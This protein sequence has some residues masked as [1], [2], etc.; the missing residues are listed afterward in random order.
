[1]C[2]E[3]SAPEAPS[4]PGEITIR[5]CR[6]FLF[7]FALSVLVPQQSFA[8]SPQNGTKEQKVLV[9]QDVLDMLKTGLPADIVAAKIKASNCNFNTDLDAL[10]ELKEKGIADNVVLAMVQ[11]PRS[12]IVPSDGKIRAFITDSQSWEV[13]GSWG[14]ANG[15]GG[16]STSGGARPQ[17]AEIIKTFTE[18]CPEVLVPVTKPPF[19]QSYNPSV[20]PLCSEELLWPLRL[21][22][23]RYGV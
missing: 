18:R 20:W 4:Q 19:V 1:V 10:K 23:M 16:G 12:V 11:A 8:N 5:M 22:P 21:F 7:V 14:A 15:S 13:R 9:N 17:T 3:K 2:T 6:F